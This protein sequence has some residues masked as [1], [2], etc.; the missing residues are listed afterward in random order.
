MKKLMNITGEEATEKILIAISWINVENIEVKDFVVTT[1]KEG[2]IGIKMNGITVTAYKHEK[3]KVV[4]KRRFWFN[5]K[6][7]IIELKVSV[8]GSNGGANTEINDEEWK[9]VFDKLIDIKY[10]YVRTNAINDIM[11]IS[12]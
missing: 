5:K 6:E 4:K 7:T 2:E 1:D 9:K 11:K 3:T 12:K 10:K 8:R